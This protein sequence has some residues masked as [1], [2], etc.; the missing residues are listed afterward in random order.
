MSEHYTDFWDKGSFKCAKCGADLFDSEAK[1]KSGTRWP[2]FR[3]AK[4]GAI[5]TR[6]DNSL[7]MHRTEILC[8][9]C[10][11]HLGHVFDDGDLL[12]DTH[13]EAGKRFCVLSESLA[14]NKGE[15]V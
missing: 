9:K 10:G 2:S 8:A 5:S 13:P 14:F 11:Q 3:Q 4:P 12:G 6:P 7:G 15:E 1:F